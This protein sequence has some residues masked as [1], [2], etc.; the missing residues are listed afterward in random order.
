MGRRD[1]VTLEEAVT[2]PRRDGVTNNYSVTG[3][4]SSANFSSPSGH[5]QKAA[6][7]S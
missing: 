5:R 1:K 3:C 2:S 4:L 6:M 7:A